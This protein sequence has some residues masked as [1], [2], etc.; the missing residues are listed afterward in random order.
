MIYSTTV[1]QKGQAT[2]PLE[3]RRFLGI[4]PYEKVAFIKKGNEVIL[5]PAKNFLNLRGSIKTQRKYSDHKAN[6]L[7]QIFVAKNHAKKKAAS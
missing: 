1:T 6:Q 5:K 7:V 3:I 2:I 4:G